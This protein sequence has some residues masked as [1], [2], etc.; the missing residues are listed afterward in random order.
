MDDF[1]DEDLMSI[2]TQG[3]VPLVPG[4]NQQADYDSCDLFDELFSQ[5]PLG[6]NTVPTDKQEGGTRFAKPVTDQEVHKA[7]QK[8]IPENTKKSTNWAVNVWKAWSAHRRSVNSTRCPS[9]LFIMAKNK[10]ELNYWMTRFVM[11][12]RRQDGKEYPPNTLHQIC[13]GILRYI[14]EIVPELDFFK[15]P[16]F[17]DLQKTLDSEMKRLRSQG[18]GCNPKTADP[19]SVQ[20]EEVL[21]STGGLGEHSPQSLVDTM[22][23]MCGFFFA[24]RSGSEH[25]QLRMGNIELVEKPGE[26]SCLV[27]TECVSKNHQGGLKHRKLKTKQVVHHANTENPER[28]FVRLYRKY[29]EHLPDIIQDDTPFYLTPIP[30]P[31]G[32]VWYKKTPIGVH[33]LE[34]TIARLCKKAGVSGFKTNHSLR[35]TA[36]TRLYQE[37]LDEQLIME[38]TGHRSLDGV[39]AYKRTSKEQQELVSAALNKQTVKKPKISCEDVPAVIDLTKRDP[40]ANIG[41]NSQDKESPKTTTTATVSMPSTPNRFNENASMLLTGCSGITINYHFHSS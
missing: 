21:W 23:Y 33:T 13:C 25:R 3:L 10:W 39:R 1:L 20:D 12:V 8:A 16:A 28:C 38:R 31:K 18:L 37:G 24:L 34:G 2:A 35:V 17:S 6:S 19:I 26:V 5:V 41:L 27:Y 9:H 29:K 32:K 22:V 36:A 15:D 40:L 14:R 7:Q 30:K 4:L 11:E